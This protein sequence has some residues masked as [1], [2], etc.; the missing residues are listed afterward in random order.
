MT[1]RQVFE[2]ALIELNK[3]EA[4]SLLLSDYNYFFNKAINQYINKRYNI[5]D[6][7]QQTTDDL[8]VLKSTS[9]L[10]PSLSSLYGSA[11]S[12]LYGNIYEVGLPN[13]YLH[14]LNCIC[15][16]KSIKNNK[17]NKEGQS[18]FYS[19]K[20]LN[21]DMWSSIIN[22]YYNRPSYKTPYFYIH[23]VNTSTSE[24]TNPYIEDSSFN[25]LGEGTDYNGNDFVVGNGIDI[26]NLATQININNNNL[27]PT[28]LINKPIASRT[29]NP[30]KVRLEIRYGKEESFRLENIYV[31]YIKSP[32]H[33]LLTQEQI[34]LTDDTS[35][36]MEFPDYVCHE[37]INELV[38]LVMENASDP[39]MQSNFQVHQSIALPTQQG[40][41]Q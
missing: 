32:Q 33:I 25:T 18:T 38:L 6:T 10:K 4:P 12:L 7:T 29:S 19:A 23:N 16:F 8:R 37:I 17:C 14:I 9:I 24:P 31:D 2:Y 11:E 22:N 35:Q 15:E 34:D 21:A 41:S 26:R 39:R 1:S 28:S 5:Y 30:S 13:D 27:N 36:I 3:I 40:Q 20:K